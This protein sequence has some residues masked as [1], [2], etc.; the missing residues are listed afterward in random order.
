MSDFENQ[1]KGEG[2]RPE[3][4]RGYE[5]EINSVKLILEDMA[6]MISR[7]AE[8]TE[9]MLRKNWSDKWKKSI[10]RAKPIVQSALEES[11]FGWDPSVIEYIWNTS[12]PLE[13]ALFGAALGA[14]GKYEA[15]LLKPSE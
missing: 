11:G 8:A 14:L 9:E 10:E 2:E 13:K 4:P 7:G 1:A 15:E 3:A 12:P 5:G 6:K